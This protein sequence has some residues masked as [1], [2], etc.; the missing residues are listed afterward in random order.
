M[1]LKVH[2]EAKKKIVGEVFNVVGDV[3]EGKNCGGV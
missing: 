3:G 2:G 1:F